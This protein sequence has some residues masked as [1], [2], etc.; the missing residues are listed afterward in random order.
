MHMYLY[1][2]LYL[3]HKLAHGDNQA[4]K[5]LDQPQLS[6]L[7][8]LPLKGVANDAEAGRRGREGSLVA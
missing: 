2:Y 7:P 6:F 4:A 1:L 3:L 8:L 5:L